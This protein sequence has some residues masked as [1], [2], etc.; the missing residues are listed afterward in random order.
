V[1]RASRDAGAIGSSLYKFKLY[2][3]GSW[4]ALSSF[5]VAP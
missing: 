2:D 1:V 5:D 3:E 4:A